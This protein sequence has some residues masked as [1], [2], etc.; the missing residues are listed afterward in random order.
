MKQVEGQLDIF[1]YMQESAHKIHSCNHCICKKCLY[2]WSNRCPN[3]ECYDDKRA[4]ENPYDKAH[5]G[6]PPRMA[7][8]N[9]N[10]PGEQAYWC[11]GGVFYPVRYCENFIKYKGCVVRSCLKANVA[12]YQDGYISC[13]L[14][15]SIGCE[16]C[17]KEFN[18][19]E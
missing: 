15:D 17:Y 4:K 3:G 1:T 14:V 16:T 11:R 10:I 5:P 8:S 19:E 13:S 9:W 18:K 7:W 2:W 6:K 12:I